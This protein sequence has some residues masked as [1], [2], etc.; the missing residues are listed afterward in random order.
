MQVGALQSR[1]TAKKA[2]LTS[3]CSRG[4]ITFTVKILDGEM[5]WH[6]IKVLLPYAGYITEQIEAAVAV[7]ALP[8]EVLD[9]LNAYCW[10]RNSN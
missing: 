4:I 10:G 5:D 1:K 8:W 3:R 9:I 6:F 7:G 2:V